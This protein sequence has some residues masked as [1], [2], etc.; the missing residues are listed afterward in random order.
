MVEKRG[1]QINMATSF[2]NAVLPRGVGTA[3][4]HT[5]VEDEVQHLEGGRG[6]HGQEAPGQQVGLLVGPGHGGTGMGRVG[7]GVGLRR[8]GGPR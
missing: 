2:S 1:V 5:G 8:G 3:R 4:G 6:G 7:G